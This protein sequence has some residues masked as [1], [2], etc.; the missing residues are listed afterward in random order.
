MLVILS[1]FSY[2][3]IFALLAALAWRDLKEYILPDPLNTALALSFMA[4]HIATH[5]RF[6]SPAQAATGALAGGG[7]LLVIRAFANKFYNADSL[8]LGDVKLMAAAGLGLGVPD[9]FMA[10]SLGAFVALLHGVVMALG[11]RKCNHK[12]KLGQINVPAGLGLAAGI[13]IVAA[14]RFGLGPFLNARF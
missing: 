12:V 5:W 10:L 2:F 14:H 13:A 6:V 7:L 8:G 1:M 3:L 11:K 9:I 4:F